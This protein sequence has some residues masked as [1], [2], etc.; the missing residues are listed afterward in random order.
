MPFLSLKSVWQ[1]A[2]C[3][4][5]GSQSGAKQVKGSPILRVAAGRGA[6][7]CS[8]WPPAPLRR[9]TA[10]QALGAG[11]HTATGSCLAADVNFG[12]AGRGGGFPDMLEMVLQEGRFVLQDLKSSSPAHG[13]APDIESHAVCLACPWRAGR[14]SGR[15]I[16]KTG[17]NMSV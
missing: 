12:F 3:G 15:K 16:W 7:Q 4:L 11:Y 14:Q 10:C 6:A 1:P 5:G 17:R 9:E 13:H 8:S 2:K